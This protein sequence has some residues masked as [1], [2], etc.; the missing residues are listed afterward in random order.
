LLVTNVNFVKSQSIGNLV[1]TFIIL[2]IFLCKSNDIWFLLLTKFQGCYNFW[3]FVLVQ[4]L[5]DSSVDSMPVS[6]T[7]SGGADV[8]FPL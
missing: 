7:K 6:L 2:F 1:I 3:G 4:N 5:C 8:I